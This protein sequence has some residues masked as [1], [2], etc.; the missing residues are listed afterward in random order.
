MPDGLHVLWTTSN[1]ARADILANHEV[2]AFKS[3][4]TASDIG[5]SSE[6]D[7][8]KS[9][10]LEIRDFL[11]TR[12]D[13]VFMIMSP[14]PRHRLRTDSGDADRTRAFADWLGSAEFLDGHPNLVY[15]DFFDHL[16]DSGN[17]LRYEYEKYHS[18]G[19]SHPNALANQTIGPLFADAIAE[20]AGR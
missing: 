5:S 3:C 7:Q 13:K 2:I 10:Y 11:D 6:L 14:P 20:A 19:D 8:F 4:Y 17:M 1:S 16:A 12:P 9:W 18:D 15:F